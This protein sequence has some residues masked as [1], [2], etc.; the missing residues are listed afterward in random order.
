MRTELQQA[1]A[2]EQTFQEFLAYLMDPQRARESEPPS[3]RP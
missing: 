3:D 2:R 1:L